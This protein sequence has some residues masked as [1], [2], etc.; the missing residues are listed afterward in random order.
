MGKLKAYL[1]L[2]RIEHGVMTGLAVVAGYLAV[3]ASFSL[4]LVLAFLSSLFAEMS[5]FAFNDIFNVEEDRVNSPERPLVRG[6]LSRREALAFAAVAST[7]ALLLALP[8]GA[9]P[10]LLLLAALAIGNAYNYYL[11]RLSVI[12]NLAV[13]GLTASSFLYGA[14]ATGLAVAEKVLLFFLIAFL[15][16]I[17]REIAKGVRD[18][19]GDIRV[20]VCTLACE[21]GV[22]QAGLVSAIFMALAVALSLA[23]PQYFALKEPFVAMLALTDA[24]FIHSIYTIVRTPTPEA[25]GIV[26][27]N[28]LIGMLVAILAFTLP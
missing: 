13:A 1:K 16:N 7:S 18:L 14:L 21:V 5:L 20:G 3:N 23:S 12:G 11:K 6:D 26:R 19:E 22:K 8:L 25:A 9:Y 4:R 15:A 24:I 17:G 2:S 10:V 28:T 27:R